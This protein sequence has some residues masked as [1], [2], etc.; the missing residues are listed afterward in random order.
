[1]QEEYY[2]RHPAF[3]QAVRAGINPLMTP[4]LASK[5]SKLQ[6]QK[7]LTSLVS[8]AT[9]KYFN[10]YKKIHI[11]F[12][13]KKFW[14]KPPLGLFQYKKMSQIVVFDQYFKQVY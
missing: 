8:L 2:H 4:H 6:D 9:T 12:L 13:L 1:M 5:K 14:M 11:F 7:F 10:K 3:A